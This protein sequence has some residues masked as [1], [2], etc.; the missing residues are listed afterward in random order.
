MPARL[1]DS[2]YAA[3][4][5]RLAAG[6]AALLAAYP[7]EP[8]TRQPVHTVYIPADRFH[9]DVVSQWG[10]AALEL[11]AEHLP[12]PS[13]LGE[14]L[15]VPAALAE[16]IRPLVRAKLGRSRSR[17]CG[18]TSRTAT[19]RGDAEEDAAADRRARALRRRRR[20]ARRRSTRHPVQ[21]PRGRTR[22]RGVC[23]AGRLPRRPARRGRCRTAS[24]VTLPKV[25][26]VGRSR[27]MADACARWSRPTARAGRAALRAADRDAAGRARRRRHGDGGADDPRRRRAAAPACTTAPTTTARRS[28][29]PRRTRAWS[30]PRPITPR[31][32][33]SWPPRAPACGFATARPTSCRSATAESP[34]RL[35]AARS[36]GPPV[37]GARLLPGLG[38]TP[39]PVGDPLRRDVRLLPGRHAG[40]GAGS[41]PTP[42]TPART[43]STSRPPRRRWRHCWCGGGSAER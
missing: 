3:L 39:G 21:V 26:S 16:Q 23:D 12:E 36:A 18:S 31:R 34:R 19:A 25:T 11:L 6:D 4:D 15:G 32:S 30:I 7:G 40:R 1:D 41:R 20:P 5:A 17:I 27:R 35:A 42:S 2:F 9:R 24:C 10:R 38:P 13:G 33:C 29:S 37:P 43:R 22:R 14:V 8:G 28:A